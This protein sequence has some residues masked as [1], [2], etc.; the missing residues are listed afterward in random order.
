M[1]W[2]TCSVEEDK[3]ETMRTLVF[4]SDKRPG[5]RVTVTTWD[6]SALAQWRY[7]EDPDH[8]LRYPTLGWTQT[9][10]MALK[11]AVI[12]AVAAARDGY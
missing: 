11:A 5:T 4:S 1:I 3:G 12:T 9:F 10:V 6:D 2:V 7:T 8:G